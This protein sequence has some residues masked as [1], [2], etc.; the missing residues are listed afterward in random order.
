MAALVGDEDFRFADAKARRAFEIAFL[1]LFDDLDEYLEL[2]PARLFN[3]AMRGPHLAARAWRE[4]AGAALSFVSISRAAM[5]PYLY[6]L[7][8]WNGLLA[9]KPVFKAAL[10]SV[11]VH[12]SGPIAEFGSGLGS[13]ALFFRLAGRPTAS[14][15][16]SESSL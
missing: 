6:D 3:L 9:G 11:L 10:E 7:L 12:T 14:I 13:V 4:A 5:D 2:P 15:E 16:I 1:G 8:F